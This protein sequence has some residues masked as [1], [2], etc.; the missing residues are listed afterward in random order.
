MRPNLTA[1]GDEMEKQAL[2]T[3]LDQTVRR[4]WGSPRVGPSGQLVP[5]QL[6]GPRLRRGAPVIQPMSAI[7]EQQLMAA[8][9]EQMGGL[10]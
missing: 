6:R 9:Q 5:N 8:M 3:M 1:F 7:Q 2:R 4:M 10:V